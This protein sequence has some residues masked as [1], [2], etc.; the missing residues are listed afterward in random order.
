MLEMLYTQAVGQFFWL[1]MTDSEAMDWRYLR[2][3]RLMF[4][5]KDVFLAYGS[6]DISPKY[7]LRFVG[8]SRSLIIRPPGGQC[9]VAVQGVCT[10]V[11]VVICGI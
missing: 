5:Y 10:D 2:Y 4:L 7:G 6:G 9:V 11:H 8:S 3:I 1:A